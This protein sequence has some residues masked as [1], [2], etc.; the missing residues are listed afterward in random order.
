M[1]TNNVTLQMI[2]YF[3]TDVRRI[4]HALK[5]TAFAKT[6]AF[7]EKCTKEQLETIEVAALLHDI[8]IPNAEK[9]YGSSD[10]KYQEIEGPPVATEILNHLNFD[11]K[12]IENV[13]YIIANHH[14]FQNGN[15][16]EFQIIIEAD[17]LVNAFEDSL[18]LQAIDYMKKN[19]FKTNTGIILLET[20]YAT[21]Q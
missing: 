19:W 20:M 17:F 12:L 14:S 3:N 13:C 9:K 8:G 2:E 16:I 7:A 11:E 4:N 5:V 10:G 15:G 6:L 1:N 18:S 21:K